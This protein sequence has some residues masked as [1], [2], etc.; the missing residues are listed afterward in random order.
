MQ[1]LP[2]IQTNFTTGEMSPRMF[3]RVDVSKYYNGVEKLQNFLIMPQGGIKRRSGTRFVAEVKDSTK[4]VIVVPFQFST[5]QAYILEIGDGYMRVYMDESQVLAS[6]GTD[7]YEITTPWTGSQ[8]FN[9][10][11]TQS[12]DVLFIAHGDVMVKK[13]SRT[14]HNDWN[15]SDYVPVDGP[16]LDPNSVTANTMAP[17]GTTGTVTL[18]TIQDTFVST[19]VGRLV[20]IMHTVS[21]NVV[22]GCAKITAFTDTKHVTAVVQDGHPF[23]ATSAVS[24]WKLG[25]W[26]SALG[27]P[28]V[29]AFHSE[30]LWFGGNRNRPQ[31]VWSTQ[32]NDFYNFGP[33]D[34]DG[35]VEAD[36]AINYFI[37][38][39]Q[40]NAIRWLM[41][42][43]ALAIG[44]T[45][46]E[47]NLGPASAAS[48]L[49]PDNINVS[50]ES[51]YGS[52]RMRPVVIGSTVIFPQRSGK[53][54]YEYGYDY[55]T[56]SYKGSDLTLF[57]E[58][59][60]RS[61]IKQM[62]Y[63]QQPNTMVWCVLNSGDI[64][65]LTYLP[66]QKVFAWGVHK[67][68]GVNTKV[69]SIASIISP[70]GTHDQVWMVVNRTINGQTKRYIEFLEEEFEPEVDADKKNAFF[71]DSGL[72]Y[73][74]DPIIEISGLNHLIGQEVALLVDG[75]THKNLTV[76]NDGKVI[77]DRKGSVIHIG[78][79][80]VS[81]MKSM[82][83]EYNDG[84]ISQIPQQKRIYR[85]SIWFHNTLGGKYGNDDH[86]DIIYDR[87][88]ADKM[89][90]SPA[91]FSGIKT[92]SFD[93]GWD[94]L[95][96]SVVEQEQ[97]L[98]MTVLATI[99]NVGISQ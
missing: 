9:L 46:A 86:L 7:I 97:P 65:A 74:G 30:R 25:A 75:A 70:D 51:T 13:I 26:G 94:K 15:V 59:V 31:T 44:T 34:I 79:P 20:R 2:I 11:F 16:W 60:T 49:S 82:P 41:S 78:L 50:R 62:A 6:N 47:F 54:L 88:A 84:L 17:S 96:Q 36:S 1:N 40:V 77:L 57:A 55:T 98:P 85:Y 56:D 99:C 35:S 66:E 95:I 5:T 53:K 8:L 64:A 83:I 80:Y 23:G 24:T 48:P 22:W 68:G 87:R 21:S 14:G 81:R 61:G 93:R 76:G 71:L 27:Y 33:S 69:E 91:L 38:T 67:L 63:Q 72:S 29:I 43:K 45:D 4:P 90:N 58:H 18:T 73:E 12:A 32:S 19:D 42:I 10:S 52:L 3:G 28:E 92:F 37:A 39:D 89:D